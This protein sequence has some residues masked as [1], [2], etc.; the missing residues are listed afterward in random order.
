MIK[1][2]CLVI[3]IYPVIVTMDNPEELILEKAAILEF[4]FGFSR[5]EADRE[6]RRRVSEG[7]PDPD[8]NP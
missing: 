5:D 6:A 4:C 2:T 3:L 1:L 7:K 8:E